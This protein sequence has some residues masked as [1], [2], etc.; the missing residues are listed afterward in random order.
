MQHRGERCTAEGERHRH[1]KDEER[2]ARREEH[3]YH[4]WRILS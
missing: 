2:D 4:G 1:P 3:R